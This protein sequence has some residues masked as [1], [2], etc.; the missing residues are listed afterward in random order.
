MIDGSSPDEV[1]VS[2]LGSGI[3]KS[4]GTSTLGDTFFSTTVDREVGN[5]SS[6][7]PIDKDDDAV[8]LIGDQDGMNAL[9]LLV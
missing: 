2:G 4:G 5:K 9:T 6:K 1:I 3:K 8:R 7:N